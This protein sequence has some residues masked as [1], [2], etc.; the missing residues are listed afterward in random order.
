VRA[1]TCGKGPYNEGLQR[2]VYRR[3]RE[4]RKENYIRTEGETRSGARANSEFERG[5]GREHLEGMG[6]GRRL[7][8]LQFSGGERKCGKKKVA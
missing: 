5:K 2:Q 6:R 7:G 4:G 3:V 1:A 8:K